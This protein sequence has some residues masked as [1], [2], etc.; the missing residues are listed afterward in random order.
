MQGGFFWLVFLL[1]GGGLILTHPKGTTSA[2]GAVQNL[3]T[4]GVKQL[5]QG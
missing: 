3:F 5:Q 4:G 2:L 1:I